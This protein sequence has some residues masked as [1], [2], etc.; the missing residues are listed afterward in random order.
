MQLSLLLVV[1]VLNKLGNELLEVALLRVSCVQHL[2]SIV[3]TLRMFMILRTS[4]V[5]G[6]TLR[7]MKELSSYETWWF[8]AALEWRTGS[9]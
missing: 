5:V 1:Q 4:R 8:G 6:G 7:N 3:V 9:R 2:L